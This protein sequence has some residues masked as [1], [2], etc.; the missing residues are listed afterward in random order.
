[1]TQ[2]IFTVDLWLEMGIGLQLY[3]FDRNVLS[4]STEDDPGT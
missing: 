1:M 3:L 2:H 4:G